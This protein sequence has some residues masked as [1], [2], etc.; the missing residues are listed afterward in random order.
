MTENDTVG[1]IHGCIVCGRT[2]NI[3]AVYSPSGKLVDCTVTSP[4]SRIVPDDRK[5]L[6]ACSR[7]TADEVAAAYK[8][9]QASTGKES[10]NN[11]EN[12]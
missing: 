12:E 8:T 2:I 3:L 5:P 9:W 4:D 11:Q 7:H 10:E 6:A 1:E